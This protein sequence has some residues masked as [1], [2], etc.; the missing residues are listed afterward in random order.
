MTETELKEFLE[1]NKSDIQ[2]AVKARVI[3]KLLQEHRWEIS[4]A[5][6]KTV[7]EFVDVNVVPAVREALESQKGVIVATAVKSL[8]NISDSLAKDLTMDAA[9]NSANEWQ[10][11]KI[12]QA[13][14][15]Y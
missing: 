5:I 4:E 2:S 12:V 7:R 10:R 9:K 6:T 3:E 13:I 11:K 8:A 1:N 15:G 14:F